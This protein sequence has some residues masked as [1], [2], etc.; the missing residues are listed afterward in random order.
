MLLLAG[1]EIRAM[2]EQWCVGRQEL[3]LHHQL[4]EALGLRTH[5]G[6]LNASESA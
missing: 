4:I 1:A 5:V 3:E 6:E 2:R